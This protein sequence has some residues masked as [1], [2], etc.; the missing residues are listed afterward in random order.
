MSLRR[1]DII[2]SLEDSLAHGALR[3]VGGG[4]A[5]RRLGGADLGLGVDDDDE[6]EVAR[7]EPLDAGQDPAALGDDGRRA[8][9]RR[10][11][12]TKTPTTL[13]AYQS[14]GPAPVS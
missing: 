4:E 11:G 7:Q 14:S 1:R 13:R 3:V 6:A 5:E 10:S 12:V 8:V 9:R 2:R